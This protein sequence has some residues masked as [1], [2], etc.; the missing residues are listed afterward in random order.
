MSRRN[1]ANFTTFND[2]LANSISIQNDGV[3]LSIYGTDSTSPV[4]SFDTTS[5]E[6]SMTGELTVVGSASFETITVNEFTSGI[7]ALATSNPGDTWDIGMVGEY[8]NGSSI[9]TGLVRDASDSLKRW[10]FFKDITT[11]PAITVE[12]LDS[13]KLDSVRMNYLY[14]NDGTEAL[15]S[16]TFHNDSGTDT[17]FYLAAAN[18]IGITAGANTIANIRYISPTSSEFQLDTT[19]ALKFRTLG[20]IDD[21]ASVTGGVTKGHIMLNSASGTDKW[22]K[23]YSATTAGTPAYSGTVYTSP[24][25]NYFM[26]NTGTNLELVR[27]TVVSS[28]TSVPDYRD[29]TS[30]IFVIG[31][32]TFETKS[33]LILPT[34]T[35]ANPSLRFTTATTTGLYIY[36]GGN[37]GLSSAGNLVL[38]VGS[39][40][41]TADQPIY[42]VNGALATPAITFTAA[43]STGM[44]RD[45]SATYENV[46]FSAS[47]AKV[48]TMWRNGSVSQ[49]V[50]GSAGTNSIPSFAFSNDAATGF[51]SPIDEAATGQLSVSTT[52]AEIFRF[53]ARSGTGSGY[54]EAYNKLKVTPDGTTAIFTLDSNYLRNTTTTKARETW[55]QAYDLIDDS[56]VVL[57]TFRA[58][59]SVG[60]DY[61]GNA[62]D[63]TVVNAAT[64]GNVVIDSSNVTKKDALDMSTNVDQYLS[65]TSHLSAFS[66]LDNVTI[67][68][69]FKISGTLSTTSTIFNCHKITGAK[70]ISIDILS[71]ASSYPN[72]LQVTVESEV[73]TTLQFHTATASDIGTPSP[74]AVKDGNWHHVVIQLG[75]SS[76]KNMLTYDGT[77]LTTAAHT[78]YFTSTG[79]NVGTPSLSTNSFNDL[80][81]NQVTIGA[82][83]NGSSA[84]QF[85]KGYLKDFYVTAKILTSTERTQLGTEQYIY[86][87][88]LDAAVINVATLNALGGVQFSSGTVSLPSITFTGDTDTGLYL[89]SAG[90]LGFSI[91]GTNRLSLN[92]TQL[93]YATD[94]MV[95]DTTNRWLKLKMNSG[96]SG[97][98]FVFESSSSRHSLRS[99]HSDGTLATNYLDWYL[100]DTSGSDGDG[101]GNNQAM[102]LSLTAATANSSLLSIYGISHVH[103][104]SV[105]APAYAFTNS[106]GMGLYRIADNDLGVA[107]NGILKLQVNTVVTV[108][109]ASGDTTT[110]LYVPLGSASLPTI[111]F[112]GD[113]NTG[114]YSSTADNVDIACA[115]S[116]VVNFS[117]SGSTTTLPI[118]IN[119]NS[120][121]AFSVNQSSSAGTTAFAVDTTNGRVGYGYSSLNW[122]KVDA[123]NST[124]TQRIKLD[125]SSAISSFSGIQLLNTNGSGTNTNAA[126]LSIGAT[127]ATRNMANI[128]F[129]YVS[130][131][132]TSNKL[133]FGFEGVSA[134]QFNIRAD[135]TVNVT[136]GFTVS[137]TSSLN[138]QVQALQ[139][140]ASTP[141]YSFASRTSDGIYSA[142]SGQIGTATSGTIRTLVTDTYTEIYGQLR[143]ASGSIS[144]PAIAFTS[145]T[146]NNSGLYLNG[147]DS[148]S[149]S[150]GGVRV[151]TFNTLSS[152]TPNRCRN[153]LE[154]FPDGTNLRLK[155]QDE[156]LRASSNQTILNYNP[157]LHF[158][159]STDPTTAI[160]TQDE[161]SDK[162]T[163]IATTGTYVTDT[164]SLTDSLGIGL[165]QYTA[166]QFSTAGSH[167]VE[168]DALTNLPL[169]DYF[170]IGIK[171]KLASTTTGSLF[172]IYGNK[173]GSTT[174]NFVK[175]TITTANINISVAG[176]STTIA[177]STT[178]TPL[179]VNVWY[180]LIVTFNAAGNSATLNGSA[181]SF[182]YST[183][184]AST[185]F[186]PAS[187]TS[188]A[189]P[190]AI[191]GGTATSALGYFAEFYIAPTTT[192]E[193]LSAIFRTQA[194]EIYTNKLQ[195][196]N[197]TSGLVDEGYI[198]RSDKGNNVIWDNSLQITAGSIQLNNSKV[199]RAPNGSVSNPALS[200]VNSNDTGLYLIGS[201]NIGIAT[202]G[203]KRIDISDSTTLITNELQLTSGLRKKVSTVTGTSATLDSTY[204]MILFSYA[205]DATNVTVTL[206]AADSNNVGR[207]YIIVK[208]GNGGGSLIINTASGSDFIDG[209][210]NTSITLTVIYD[211]VRLICDGANHWYTL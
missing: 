60:Q 112:I 193:A 118:T 33:A 102:R 42:A 145:D 121:S 16:I 164:I 94:A 73:D 167:R 182:T 174:T 96:S 58:D 109:N 153:G 17:G 150:M 37:I 13:T 129:H 190:V 122:S 165:L 101:L 2:I 166:V 67:G 138:G 107:A 1:I 152:S 195:I 180:N 47:G 93:L 28:E 198:L 128:G 181:L 97:A 141:S 194:H 65:L 41:V 160:T 92:S 132:S 106:T 72:A 202:G 32:S 189:N 43:T 197:S 188:T 55:V 172:E 155:I 80:T 25:C 113:T 89:P 183:G 86:A 130:S 91:G 114:L 162:N 44:W 11:L 131:G 111:S 10:T 151:W 146:G 100:Y 15:P 159:F 29:T 120:T 169:L 52:S 206:P 24:T 79:N 204:N 187:W 23:L 161:S 135:G 21:T 95:V 20:T 163:I 3:G 50:T 77:A 205:T 149:V 199:L 45:T 70:N 208:T 5:Q 59:G 123:Y 142:A 81:F 90:T 78:L 75:S 157:I 74:I 39:A 211:R 125:T 143:L 209:A 179:S 184:N 40:A 18:D 196:G 119:N 87:Y 38:T 192:T 210:V 26:T 156:K 175:L 104:G 27:N 4:F 108:G 69:W 173:S 170:T 178:S 105:S 200:F 116:N 85:Y 64:I 12:T 140:S 22:M 203:T 191:V 98:R 148:M 71:D 177:A 53:R 83:Y 7:Q 76:T 88:A 84:S 63:A 61:S 68:F 34:G 176:A 134:D 48:A 19:T 46:S 31:P 110:K 103:N 57:Y 127:S 117:S 126:V 137:S 82:L 144:A 186:T 147:E 8:N 35:A 14:V 154:V 168:T 185:L 30:Q 136:G 99:S 133:Q 9:Y 139:G 51:Y 115:G 6:F 36:G 49:I 62:R 201:D 56:Q 54:L 66:V 171:F 207:E 124:T 158:K